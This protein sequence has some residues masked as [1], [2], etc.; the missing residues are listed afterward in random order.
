M[1]R[2]Q[3]HASVEPGFES[4]ETDDRNQRP[5]ASEPPRDARLV[6]QRCYWRL[7]VGSVEDASEC[8][9]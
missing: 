6:K 2:L 3:N 8:G 4:E 5:S 9:A 1:V 7:G